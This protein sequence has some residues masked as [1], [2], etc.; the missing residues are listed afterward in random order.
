M[1]VVKRG[2]EAEAVVTYCKA[3]TDMSVKGLGKTIENYLLKF[4]P[5][6]CTQTLYQEPQSAGTV[7]PP[8]L[9]YITHTANF[10]NGL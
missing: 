3:P 9:G 5:C 6:A 8:P 2:R 10:W 4:R 7:P 1:K